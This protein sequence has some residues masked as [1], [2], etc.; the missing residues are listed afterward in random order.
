[1]ISVA[2]YR[3][4]RDDIVAAEAMRQAIRN[5]IIDVLP[6]PMPMPEISNETPLHSGYSRAQAGTWLKFAHVSH[7]RWNAPDVLRQIEDAGFEPKPAMLIEHGDKHLVICASRPHKDGWKIAPIWFWLNQDAP[8]EARAYYRAPNGYLVRVS[9]ETKAPI[10]L[11]C[12]KINTFGGWYFASGSQT[13]SFPEAWMTA[14]VDHAGNQ[15]LRINA[16]SGAHIVTPHRIDG[17]IYF[18]PITNHHDF[19]VP[20]SELLRILKDCHEQP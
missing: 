5:D 2:D 1:M 7:D 18:T 11:S 4:R 19:P 17:A 12:R 8:N 13:V 20:P 14:V 3:A 9:I 10:H 16:H 6:G 15:L